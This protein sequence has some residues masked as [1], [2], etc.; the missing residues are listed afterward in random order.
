MHP[1]E[2]LRYVARAQGADPASLVEETA[3]ALGAL[4]FDPAGLVVAC[5][6]IV[7]RHPFTGALWWL[8]ATVATSAEPF[9]AV[10]EAAD[11]IRSDRTGAELA[12]A[13][14]DDATVVTIGAP[15]VIGDG[16]VRRGDVRVL[17]LDAGH[18]ATS[19]VRRLERHDVDYE[20]VDAGAAGAVTR[21]ADVVLIEALAVDGTRV[22]APIGSSTIAASATAWGTPVWLVA[23]TGRRLPSPMLDHMVGQ[24]AALTDPDGDCPLDAWELDVE[25]LPTSL[26]TSVVGPHGRMPMGPSA[27]AAEC[28]MAHELLRTA[29]M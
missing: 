21:T 11:R 7:Q 1:I 12:A 24:V 25:V 20:P 2:H 17:A 5:R 14:A 28:A 9:D 16:L 27:T 23:G 3:H 10:W 29:Q 4:R 22:V 15:G 8:C 6:R 13:L 26:L 18:T 19:F